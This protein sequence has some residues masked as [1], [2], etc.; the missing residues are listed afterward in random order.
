MIDR[1]REKKRQ[2]HRQTDRWTNE[3]TVQREGEKGGGREGGRERER[4]REITNLIVLISDHKENGRVS[5][6]QH[7]TIHGAETDSM[8]EGGID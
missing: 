3:D 4:E 5:K 1:E 2:T 7:V 6:R 8:F